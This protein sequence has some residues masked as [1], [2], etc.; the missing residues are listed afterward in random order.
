VDRFRK[1][2]DSS[3]RTLRVLY[4]N[5][6]GLRNS[7]RYR[8]WE[9]LLDGIEYTERLDRE[10]QIRLVRERLADI[11]GFAIRN[12]PYYGKFSSLGKELNASN[13][14]EMLERLPVVGKEE[15]NS[16]PGAFMAAGRRDYSTSRTSG[17]TGTPLYVHMDR[18]TFLL[19]DALWW[20]RTRWA[21]FERGDWVARLVGDPIIPLKEK[22]PEKPWIVSM[23]DRRIYLSTFHLSRNTAR[24][25]GE[26][27]NRK[28]P[29]FIIG[30]PSSLEILCNYLNE[31]GFEI[32]WRPKKILFSSEPMYT[33][34]EK[35][36]KRVF[37]TEIRGLY[38]SGEKVISAAQCE[39]GTYHLSLVD[40]YLEGQF[41]IMEN[42]QPGAVTTLTNRV[43]PLIRYEI[44]DV[45]KA[46][47]SMSCRCGRT[48]PAIDPVITKQEDWVITPSGRK[49]SPSAI[50]WAFIHQD[51]SG[52]HKAQVVQE[53][54]RSVRVYLNT[55]EMNFQRYKDMLKESMNKVFFGEMDVEII[56]SDH[57]D[58]KQSGKSRFIVNKLRRGF[59]DA[60][61][62]PES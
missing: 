25:M 55:D 34:Q 14:F 27:L 4:I 59:E 12:V 22:E 5:V 44:G 49:I 2:Y 10:A 29:A 56:K 7:A 53:D 8:R 16:D 32:G 51:I 18:Y 33:H 21:G 46:E 17:T 40:G 54:E 48:L 38:G 47:P 1:I 15:I 52:I 39:E 35:I 61:A 26:I 19:G 31:S 57:I 60:T 24:S 37:K 20:R 30:Y 42:R 6:Y 41:G 23:L 50:T 58:V 9:R 11:I 62:D 28:R 43:M 13:V 3:G 45:I 36:V